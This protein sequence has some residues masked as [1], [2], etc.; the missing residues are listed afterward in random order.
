MIFV[1]DFKEIEFFFVEIK[2]TFAVVVILKANK[3]LL[4]VLTEIASEK[5]A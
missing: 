5:K 2:E 4:L 1:V 3:G